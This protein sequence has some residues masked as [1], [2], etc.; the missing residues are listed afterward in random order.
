MGV[1]I[2]VRGGGYILSLLRSSYATVVQYMRAY[3]SLLISA[4]LLNSSG[5]PDRGIGG[6]NHIFLL[7]S[8][9]TR[10]HTS[11]LGYAII[12]IYIDIYYTAVIHA[13]MY[14]CVTLSLSM[15]LPASLHV[16]I[17]FSSSSSLSLSLFFKRSIKSWRNIIWTRATTDSSSSSSSSDGQQRRLSSSASSSPGQQRYHRSSSSLVAS[18]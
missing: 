9:N 2:Y 15:C 7:F 14:L 18:S 10:T 17:I 6:N 3:V 11:Y 4:Y 12:Y 5:F 16:I 8:P 1:C 13:R